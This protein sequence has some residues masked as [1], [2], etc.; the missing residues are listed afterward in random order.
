MNKITEHEI[1]LNIMREGKQ[2]RCYMF[3]KFLVTYWFAFGQYWEI[4]N[5]FK[6][7]YLKVYQT[8]ERG[9]RL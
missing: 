5:V 6:E 3:P 4:M 2:L 7:E 8:D 9:D 1:A